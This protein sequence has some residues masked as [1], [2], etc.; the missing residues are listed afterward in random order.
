MNSHGQILLSLF[1]IFL[2]GTAYFHN[3]LSVKLLFIEL[4]VN[5]ILYVICYIYYIYIKIL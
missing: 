4:M 5:P 3:H 1:G 2:G